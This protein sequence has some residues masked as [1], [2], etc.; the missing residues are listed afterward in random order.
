M[1]EY[2]RQIVRRDRCKLRSQTINYTY[3]VLYSGSWLM[4]AEF[5]PY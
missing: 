2:I 5:L 4:S 3:V 1:S